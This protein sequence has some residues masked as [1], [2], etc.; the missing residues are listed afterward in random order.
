MAKVDYEL[1][2]KAADI[3]GTDAYAPDPAVKEVAN[4]ILDNLILSWMQ[5]ADK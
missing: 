5:T 4:R 1:I 3:P 2:I